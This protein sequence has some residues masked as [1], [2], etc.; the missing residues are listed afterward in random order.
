MPTGLFTSM[1]IDVCCLSGHAAAVCT[2]GSELLRR[3]HPVNP[4]VGCGL[5]PPVGANATI[6]SAKKFKMA[7]ETVIHRRLSQWVFLDAQEWRLA[8]ASIVPASTRS[9]RLSTECTRHW[10]HALGWRWA[11]AGRDRTL[12]PQAAVCRNFDG[13][14][15]S[16]G[17]LTQVR[18][19]RDLP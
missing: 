19:C 14:L 12:S 18:D 4:D 6:R 3:A 7:S 2:P 5:V 15:T 11:V 17:E 16:C 10:E 8:R 1:C 13:E 9:T